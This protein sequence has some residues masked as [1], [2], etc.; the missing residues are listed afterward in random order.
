MM[1]RYSFDM[2]AEADLIEKAV[3]AVLGE[4]LR[5]ADIFREA[6]GTRK[7]G[8]KEMGDRVRDAMRSINSGGVNR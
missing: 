7:V 2:G 1:F 8:T 5:T 4:G 3:T 6:P